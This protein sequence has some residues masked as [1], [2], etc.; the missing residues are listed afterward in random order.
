M[1]SSSRVRCAGAAG[2]RDQK[3]DLVA[4]GEPLVAAG[5][6]SAN[7]WERRVECGG[8]GRLHLADAGE[9]RRDGGLPGQLDAEPASAGG[10]G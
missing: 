4:V 7:N 2:H 5:M 8:D 10:G 1:T 3:G 6:R 9:Q